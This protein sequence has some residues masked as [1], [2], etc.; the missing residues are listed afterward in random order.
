MSYGTEL[1]GIVEGLFFECEQ[2]LSFTV[3]IKLLIWAELKLNC[4][5]VIILGQTNRF[6]HI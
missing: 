3:Y 6:T 1:I 4:T 2:K 5:Y